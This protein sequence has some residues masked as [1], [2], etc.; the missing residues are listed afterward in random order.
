M[1]RIP[2]AIHIPVDEITGREIFREVGP[3]FELGNQGTVRIGTK[4]WRDGDPI[5]LNLQNMVVRREA[6]FRKILML[7]NHNNEGREFFFD[8]SCW[9]HVV[10]TTSRTSA[11]A[12]QQAQ[13]HWGFWT[14]LGTC[15][16]QGIENLMDWLVRVSQPIWVIPVLAL[17]FIYSMMAFGMFL[18]FAAWI[19]I[20]ILTLCWGLLFGV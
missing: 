3:D 6:G 2:V 20:G 11:S 18:L 1:L 14:A 9:H 8:G 12:F 5:F 4:G 10:E 16:S 15:G 7:R 19:L 13:G 17:Q